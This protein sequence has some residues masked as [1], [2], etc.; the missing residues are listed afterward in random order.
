MIPV[1]KQAQPQRSLAPIGKG[2]FRCFRCRSVFAVKDGDWHHW[3]SMEVHLC[4]ACEKETR[5]SGERKS[6]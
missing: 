2:Q 3:N 5:N 4:L 1:S 6:R